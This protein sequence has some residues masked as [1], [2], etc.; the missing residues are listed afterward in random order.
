MDEKD[1]RK[2][3]I[4]HGE[5]IQREKKEKRKLRHQETKEI[6]LERN[7]TEHFIKCKKKQR[8]T[9]RKNRT[10][11]AKKETIEIEKIRRV[12][13][14]IEKRMEDKVEDIYLISIRKE[15]S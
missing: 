4:N 3:A 2:N 13:K 11:V 12:N 8:K 6:P 14:Y 1:Q 9:G 7:I 10:G 15:V 5:G